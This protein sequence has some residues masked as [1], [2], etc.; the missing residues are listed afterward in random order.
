LGW[1]RAA[2]PVAEWE[3]IAFYPVVYVLSGIDVATT[4]LRIPEVFL[5]R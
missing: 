3:E 1:E 4:I 5:E 2:F